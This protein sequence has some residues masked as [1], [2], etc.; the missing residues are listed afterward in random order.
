MST[1]QVERSRIADSE[2]KLLKSMK[3]LESLNDEMS[4]CKEEW[5]L[6]E[7]ENEYLKVK[8]NAGLKNFNNEI[9]LL[10]NALI[11]QHNKH[12]QEMEE[13]LIEQQSFY[14]Q[15]L[16]TQ[17]NKLKKQFIH[18]NIQLKNLTYEMENERNLY[19]TKISY[20]NITAAKSK[21]EIVRLLE[22]IDELVR[23]EERS[24]ISS[25]NVLEASRTFHR[26]EIE[27]LEFDNRNNHF[28]QS[29]LLNNERKETRNHDVN[30]NQLKVREERKNENEDEMDR[31]VEENKDVKKRYEEEESEGVK[32]IVK[33]NEI[34]EEVE[35]EMKEMEE[36]QKR[37]NE[38]RE[39]E[40]E[41]EMEARM[42]VS[43]TQRMEE[44]KN[45]TAQQL[46][47]VTREWA[48]R[49][50]ILQAQVCLCF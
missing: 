24:K 20:L 7:E 12:K 30:L 16:S 22:C 29:S 21:S 36:M 23:N 3:K 9:I 33:E 32:E 37:E 49:V 15:S 43:Y 11:L 31:V 17:D 48:Q 13:S 41:E 14:D 45:A 5:R 2:D 28:D 8:N 4:R 6:K 19:E 10:N 50:A 47:V 46:E 27:H 35:D 34:V 26:R 18:Q 39:K 38:S 40:K 42:E 1:L 25:K 44:L